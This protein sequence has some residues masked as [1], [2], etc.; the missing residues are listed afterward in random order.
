[1]LPAYVQAVRPTIL[2]NIDSHSGGVTIEKDSICERIALQPIFATTPSGSS[3]F[4]ADAPDTTPAPD[5][6]T[7]EPDGFISL[8][9]LEGPMTRNGGDCTMGT[10]QIRNIMIDESRDPDCRGHI[11]L[12]D[13]PGGMAACLSDLRQATNE[14][15]ANGQKVYMLID[16][17]A[18]SG[19]AF[20]AAMCD[21]VFYTND[22]N[23]IGSIGMY[24]SFF[25]LADG[26]KNAITSEVYHEIY[27]SRSKDKNSCYR[28]VAEGD[29]EQQQKELDAKLELIIADLTADRPSILE[30]QK[31]GQ[32]YRAADVVGSLVDG[33]STIDDLSRML[34]QDYKDR[35]GSPLPLKLGAQSP[36][37]Q[38]D[39]DPTPA[40]PK[41]P[42]TMKQYPTISSS[43][44]YDTVMESD[45][46]GQLTLQAQEA[47]SLEA[48]LN[49][50]NAQIARQAEQLEAA[51]AAQQAAEQAQHAAE[52]ALADAQAAADEQRIAH[53]SAMAELNQQL[54]DA[55][56]A[57][58][59]A[60]TE[61]AAA[62]QSMTEERDAAN[63]QVVQHQQTISDQNKTIADLRSANKRLS[64]GQGPAIKAGAEP[65]ADTNPL[66]APPRILN[67]E[68]TMALLAQ[69][70]Q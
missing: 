25:T 30:A 7:A 14:A 63:Q 55:Q 29:Y 45:A 9:H 23:Q 40:N 57:A 8:Y 6:P 52:Q 50:A 46:E 43:L 65:Q 12:T 37:Q 31:T 13:T 15:R 47:D 36:A 70:A 38:S 17:I 34:Y 39:P 54:T 33:K 60:A 58:Q 5:S 18:A 49:R 4:D 21:G 22:D 67:K 48:A 59:T 69:Q 20:A 16:G 44:Q 32:M 24:A 51:N 56:T 27:A 11:I 28:Q 61:A 64:A 10:K 35:N 26:A 41:Q 42:N 66:P 1:M 19:G 68:E 62:L 2:Q 53:E 3:A